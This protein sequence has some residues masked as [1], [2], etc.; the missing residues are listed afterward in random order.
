MQY[1]HVLNH[2]R[3]QLTAI[4]NIP[5]A[6]SEGDMPAVGHY[7]TNLGMNMTREDKNPL[8]TVIP[9]S[10]SQ[11]G[12]S[13]RQDFDQLTFDVIEL[14]DAKYTMR[15]L[16]NATSKSATCHSTFQIRPTQRNIDIGLVRNVA[17]QSYVGCNDV[18]NWKS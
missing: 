6:L 16:S 3:F 17:K 4:Q 2:M 13:L 11:L 14:N 18:S 5:T 15:Q 12:T 10:Y 7:A 9:K 8:K 1:V